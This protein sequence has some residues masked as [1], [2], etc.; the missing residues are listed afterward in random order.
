M[1]PTFF[2]TQAEFRKWLLT[3]HAATSELLVGFYRKGSGRAG[4]TYQEAVDEALC[5]GWIDGVK[6]RV[7]ESSYTHRF[8]PRKAG[9]IWSVVNT[10]RAKALITLGLMA[11][12]GLQAFERRDRKKTK[13]YSYEREHAVFDPAIARAFK[14]NAPA[15]TFFRAQPPGYQR[16][17]TFWIMSA[18][19]D[20]ARL[21]RLAALV[22]M[23]A[24]GK[25]MR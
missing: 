7:D 1:K 16:I 18:K 8:T 6:K 19:T 25:R 11:A 4:I 22:K 2:K 20:E 21:R 13:Q 5:F 12:P 24:E 9:S 10:N 3:H 15:W 14:A 23:S 17:L